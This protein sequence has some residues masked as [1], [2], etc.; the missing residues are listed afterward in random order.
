MC[1]WDNDG[2]VDL[3]VDS[4]TAAWFRNVGESQDGTVKLEYMGELSSTRLEGHTTC[5]TA[6]DWDNDGKYD[7][8]VGGEDGRFYLVRNIIFG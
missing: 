4:R 7:L 5:P 6:V 3:I 2:R 8:L 1:D